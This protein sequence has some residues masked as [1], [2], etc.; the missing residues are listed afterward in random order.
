MSDSIT[1]SDSYNGDPARGEVQH[2]RVGEIDVYKTAV[3]EMSN[4]AYLLAAGD[5]AVL[6]DAADE[7]D[8]L[9][10][11]ME[12]VGKTVKYVVTTHAHFDH[13]QALDEVLR[14]TGAAHIASTLD[15]PE[16]PCPTDMTMD[17][18]DVLFFGPGV[19]VVCFILR[20][21]T[22]GGLCLALDPAREDHED[23]AAH[24]FVGDSL[25]PGGVGKTTT[26]EAFG[27]L[28]DDVEERVFA[29]YPDSTQ[30]H[31]GHGADT[32]VGAERPHLPEWRQRGW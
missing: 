25:F 22:R 21:H 5:E 17:H 24:L 32:T 28:M 20:G 7:A 1:I 9:L 31:P 15:A 3:G 26:N 14:T 8:H 2:V 11:L 18:G 13:F 30:V 27:Q 6:I 12:H 16:L 19:D 23:D 10:A 4:N 29:V